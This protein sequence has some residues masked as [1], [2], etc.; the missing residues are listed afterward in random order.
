MTFADLQAS[1]DVHSPGG[2]LLDEATLSVALTQEMAEYVVRISFRSKR[3]TNVR[4][5]FEAL[6]VS[7]RQLAD[8][9]L[10]T[11]RLEVRLRTMHHLDKATRDGVYHLFEDTAEPDPSVVDLNS[12]LAEFDECAATT[13]AAPERRY[14]RFSRARTRLIPVV[15]ARFLFEGLSTLMDQLLISNSRYIRLA[16][17]FGLSKM[18]RNILALQQNLKNIGDA[19]LEVDFER[20][21][22]FWEVF[23]RG[24]QVRLYFFSF[25]LFP[26]SFSPFSS[27]D[28]SSFLS[29]SQ[30]TLILSPARRR[31]STPS[32]QERSRTSS[33]TTNPSS[34]SCAA[35]TNPPK[36]NPLP[37][38]GVEEEIGGCTTST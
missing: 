18:L 30:S 32:E 29:L 8:T 3:L 37:E 34:T 4:R 12:N 17:A 33:R 19:P 13:L 15:F 7:Y 23:G 2:N 6:R 22:K 26:P 38:G 10:F 36:T 35:S 21:R 28:S 16:N 20:S 11:M 14:V 5:P 9:I 27:L 31:C 24:P 25:S 1:E